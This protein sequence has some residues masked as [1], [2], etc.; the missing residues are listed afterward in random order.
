MAKARPVG[1]CPTME[2]NYQNK[3]TNESTSSERINKIQSK[4]LYRSHCHHWN[5]TFSENP[6][7]YA[8]PHP[9]EQ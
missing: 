1:N 8:R 3:D 2:K 7:E 5:V 6:E 4:V 9:N